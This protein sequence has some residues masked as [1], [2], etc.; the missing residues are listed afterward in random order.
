M[1]TPDKNKTQDDHKIIDYYSDYI[2]N[3]F[4]ITNANVF[5]YHAA[6][7]ADHYGTEDIST[8]C[9]LLYKK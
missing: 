3:M 8:I 9:T 2:I 1:C 4:H 6:I 7:Q 5:E